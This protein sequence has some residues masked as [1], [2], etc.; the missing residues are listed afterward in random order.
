MWTWS[1]NWGEVTP[2]IVVGTCPMKT[3]DID[4]LHGE[5]RVSALLSLQHDDCLAYWGIDYRNMLASGAT[6]GITMERCQIRDFDI[7]DMRLRLPRA[8]HKLAKLLHVGHRVYVHCTAGMGRSPLTV[9]AY[10]AAIDGEEPWAALRKIKQ[11]RPEAVPS[12]EAFEGFRRDLAARHHERIARR[13]YDLYRQGAHPGDA[14]QDWRQAEAEVIR[15]AILADDVDP[16]T[17]HP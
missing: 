15:Q 8:V 3:T 6:L 2:H 4:R 12:P 10:L 13:A 1:L 14:E 7:S 9:W 17:I 5:A 11:G 16:E